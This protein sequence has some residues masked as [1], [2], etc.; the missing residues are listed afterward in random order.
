MT[1]KNNQTKGVKILLGDPKTAVRRLSL[2]MI[3]AIFLLSLYNA[4]DA[5]WVSGLGPDALA[6]IGLVFPFFFI[7]IGLA[8]G[9]GTG[10]GA[11]LS[12]TIGEGKQKRADQVARQSLVLSVLVAIAFTIPLFLFSGYIFPLIGA[13]SAAPYAETYGQI[14]FAGAIFIFLYNYG[15]AILR[16]EGDARRAMYAMVVSSILNIILDPIF[17]YGLDWGIA[18]A[19]Y[20]TVFSLFVS[21]LLLAW[22]MAGKKDTYVSFTRGPSAWDP[23]ITRDILRV[24]LP[25]SAEFIAGAVMILGINL[26]IVLV[27]ST[28]DI[29]VAAIGWRVVNI[30][31]TPLFAIGMAVVSVAGANFGLRRYHAIDTTSSYGAKIGIG[32]SVLLSV[33]TFI[34]APQ[35]AGLFTLSE[36]SAHLAP[37]I[38]TFLRIMCFFYPAV[39]FGIVAT[40]VFQGVG[41]G[42]SALVIT[43]IRTLILTLIFAWLFA[44]KLEM[45]VYGI[46][47]G[48]VAG[49]LIGDISGYIWVKWYLRLL[50]KEPI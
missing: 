47:W 12:R 26:L 44:I 40:S 35:I 43:I 1:E 19:A 28:D 46:W 2:P 27:A 7:A 50:M 14:V 6:A 21:C 36:Q 49:N 48:M 11:A 31:M 4:A 24:G 37:E 17:I 22:W 32:I 23:T 42:S 18:G 30:A 41:K 25:A 5:F 45:G 29:A 8:M 34:L 9:M 15:T 3:V 13:G 39:P 16:G 20:A 10:A 33:V 38:I